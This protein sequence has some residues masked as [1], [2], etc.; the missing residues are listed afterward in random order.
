MRTNIKV[1]HPVKQC[2]ADGFDNEVIFQAQFLQVFV[3]VI[4]IHK[5][6]INV[7]KQGRE[8]LLSVLLGERAADKVAISDC[9][10]LTLY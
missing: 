9:I 3:K 2:C 6:R 4:W 7:S 1:T 8:K 5:Q 10:L